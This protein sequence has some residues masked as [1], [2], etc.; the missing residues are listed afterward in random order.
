MPRISIQ[1]AVYNNAPYVGQAIESMLAQTFD[2]FEFLIVNDGSTDGSG[3]IIDGYAARDPRIR[4]LH[5]DNRGTAASHNRALAEGAA[6][7]IARMDGDDDC[8]PDR[9]EKQIAFLDAHPDYGVIG[10]QT[11]YYDDAGRT[12][13][14]SE[15]YPL[16]HDSFL[17]AMTVPG[18][19]L[20]N[21]AS[22]LMKADALREIGGYRP[23]FRH[24]EDHDLWLRLSE[25]TRVASLPEALTYYRI[26]GSQTSSRHIA[27][28]AANAAM[29]WISHE[30]RL[31]GRADPF[32]GIA[33]LPG[34][35]RLADVDRITGRDGDAQIVREAIVT[36]MLYSPDL[37]GPAFP[38]LI[39][40]LKAGGH[41]PRPGRLALRL[42]KQGHPLRA[43]QV[44]LAT[45]A[46]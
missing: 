8:A 37:A 4:A 26:H 27:L 15:I 11:R 44:A 7:L 46:G 5:Q 33:L 34:L 6:P 31:A 43:A 14:M 41:V 9:L 21:H 16:D 36:R 13:P 32:D 30:A 10:T 18:T 19:P 1:M 42:A 2:D 28:Q 12:W 29:S 23:Q 22:L 40:Y 39:D 38:A 3:A 25:V 24:C 45:V 35:D 20:M 17:A